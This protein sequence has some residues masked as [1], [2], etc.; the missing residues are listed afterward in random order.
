MLFL[1]ITS[2][3]AKILVARP[4]QRVLK[5]ESPDKQDRHSYAKPHPIPMSKGKYADK[6]RGET[7][8][9]Q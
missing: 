5:D 8:K 1:S 9:Q 4:L 7:S 3:V 2:L 6:G